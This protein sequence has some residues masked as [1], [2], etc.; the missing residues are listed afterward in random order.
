[1]ITG[2]GSE[3]KEEEKQFVR[4]KVNE[5]KKQKGLFYILFNQ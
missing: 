5:K 3:S 1:M 2:K 4:E